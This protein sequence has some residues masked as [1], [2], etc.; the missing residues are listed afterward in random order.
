MNA[1]KGLSPYAMVDLT[2]E[3]VAEMTQDYEDLQKASVVSTADYK[4]ARAK[5]KAR[6]PPDAEGFMLMLKRFTN[7]LHALFSS[8]FPMY[9][10][11]YGIVQALRDYSPN[12]RSKLSHEVKTC[13]LWIILLQARRFSQGKMSGNNSCLGEFTN[14]VNLIKAKNCETI[15]HVEVPTELLSPSTTKRKK[16]SEA[17]AK[18]SEEGGEEKDTKKKARPNHPYSTELVDF[19][20]KPL[21]E[22]GNPGLNAICEY[23]GAT[24][25]QLL[26]GLNRT[27]CRQ[28]LIWRKMQI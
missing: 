14:M 12:A 27:D 18:G 9:V 6:T 28:Y 3:D 5:L 13:I 2:E 4:A 7:L 11:M 25:E 15:T 23:P 8:Q 16:R 10:Q 17:P 19:F 26:P 24:Q 20:K 21:L 1:A 22:A